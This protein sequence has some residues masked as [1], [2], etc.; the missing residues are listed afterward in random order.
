VSGLWAELFV[1]WN[2]RDPKGLFRAW[3]SSPEE[4]YDLSSGTQRIEV[5][6]T[7]QRRRVHH[8]SLEQLTPP[9]GCKVVIASLFVERNGGGTSLGELVEEIRTHLAEEPEL[10]ERLDRVVA[11]TLGNTLR[12][13]LIARFDRELAADSLHFFNGVD[14]PR[15]PEPVPSGVS[16]VHFKSDLSQ[17]QPLS[18][19]ILMSDGGIFELLTSHSN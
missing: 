1:I 5:K 19:E 13:G 12:Q 9:S 11:S 8:F 2:S 6:S 16:D 14:A 7:S 10:Q 15:I 3:H 17:C 4:K 18:Q